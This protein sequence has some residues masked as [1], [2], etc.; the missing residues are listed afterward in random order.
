VRFAYDALGR[1][2]SKS[3]VQ[4]EVRWLWD[5]DKPVHELGPQEPMTTWLSE[6]GRHAPLAKLRGDA[7]YSIVTDHLGTPA[8]LY[9]NG[10]RL[11]WK[12]RLDINGTLRTDVALTRC[13][14]RWPGQY[15]DEETGLYYNRFRYYD[16][17]LRAIHQ[18]GSRRPARGFGP[19]R[20]YG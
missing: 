8:T 11:A 15:E 4:G 20:L 10:G 2:V 5:G 9:D 7:R 19:V 6:P 12:G 16:P 17:L 18:P 13:T 3:G 14:W 1:R